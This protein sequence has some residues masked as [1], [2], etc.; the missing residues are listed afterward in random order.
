[1]REREREKLWHY[2]EGQSTLEMV[3]DVAMAQ[4]STMA[5]SSSGSTSIDVGAPCGGNQSADVANDGSVSGG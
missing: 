4:D 3:S 1:M 5:S 2:T